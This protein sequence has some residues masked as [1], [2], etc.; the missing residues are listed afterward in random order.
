MSEHKSILSRSTVGRPAATSHGESNVFFR[1]FG[2]SD[3]M[4]ATGKFLRKH[5]WAWP[6]IAA[7]VLGG[8]GWWVNHSV[9]NAL[10]QQRIE[11]LTALRDADIAAL[12]AWIADQR[13]TAELMALDEPLRSLGQD[14][15]QALAAESAVGKERAL[16]NAKAQ[17]D[18][19]ARLKPRTQQTGHHGFF[20]VA[21]TGVILAAD[22]DAAVGAT[23]T[24]YRRT[25]FDKALQGETTVS[26]PYRSPL[27]L[28]DGK[29]EHKVNLPSMFVA[30]PLR[31]DKGQPIAALG[32][33]IRPDDTFTKIL[34]V[35]RYGSTGETYAFDRE[36]VLLSQSRF[37]DDL[38]RMG[39]LLDQADSQSILT[40]EVRDPL[41]DLTKGKHSAL[42]RGEQ[43][44]TA[45]AREATKGG[46]GVN[47]DGYRDY[48]GVPSIGAW[49]WLD[50][51]DFGVATEVDQDEAFRALYILRRAIWGL[52]SL[53]LLAALGI[54]AAMAFI[55]RQQKALQKATLTAKQLGQYALEDKIGA[56]GM[57][58]VFKARHAMLRRPTAVKLL[59]ADKMSPAAVARFERE[60]QMTSALSH[61]NT[62]AIYDYGHTPDGIF[63]YAME[64][65]EGV[66][67]DELVRC[68]GPVP[69]ARA[70]HILR[71]VCGALAEAH[72]QNLVHRDIKPANI[73]LTTRG[74]LRDFVK[75][76]DFGLVKALENKD[77]ANLTSMNAITGTP[78][79]ISPEAVQH[80]ELVD[81][82][83]DVYGIGAVAYFLLTGHAPFDGST[84]MEI[85]LHHVRTPPDPLSTRAKQPIS[86]AL[87]ALI[88][89]C[90]AKS[91]DDRPRDAGALLD[92]LDA[93]PVDVPWTAYAANEW[94]KANV[95]TKPHIADSLAVTKR[96]PEA[97]DA[98]PSI[99][100]TIGLEVR[101]E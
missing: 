94:W 25:V 74:G 9:E 43:P 83:S 16:L 63:Y 52:M 15:L 24:G 65:L 71:Q 66:N 8:V 5:L 12:R 48:R 101:K 64:Y 95:E 23:L 100:V 86:A 37:D 29:G 13:S 82:R 38:K 68:F 33:R 54:F 21:P 78:L 3:T 19:R 18:F 62:V 34:Q 70:I 2:R 40:V 20:L 73:F 32:L 87:E 39:L 14:L 53:L 35:A 27:L 47:V 75:V 97:T 84:V 56:G 42:R 88:L 26:K 85:C 76:L 59:D 98:G 92:A 60:V 49:K 93:C 46:E 91:R 72:A 4:E 41:V 44:L 31:G 79:Y 89:R 55:G 36:G 10:R 77:Q 1:L 90:L 61:P 99:D 51:V 11:E 45:M 57:G 30:A 7:L 50:D 22:I 69:E 58:S 96:P 67:L 6:V 81:A 17:S 80:P 28:D